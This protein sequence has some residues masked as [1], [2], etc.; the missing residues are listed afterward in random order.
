MR[1]GVRWGIAFGFVAL[2]GSAPVMAQGTAA[3]SAP[4]PTARA[5]AADVST[6]DSIISVLY[7]VISGPVGQP[8]QWERFATLFH[9]QA[10]LMPSHCD[11]AG[12]C[13]VRVL[14]PPEYRQLAD[15]F[16]VTEGFRE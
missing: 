10:R 2:L 3:G 1:R 4:A 15:S 16:L 5:A 11:S 7:A 12:R 8:R 6:I 9:P 13:D 14:T